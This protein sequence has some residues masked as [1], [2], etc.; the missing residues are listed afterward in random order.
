MTCFFPPRLLSPPKPLEGHFWLGSSLGA[1]G[2]PTA[3]AEPGGGMVCV[4][5]VPFMEVGA[6]AG[7]SSRSRNDGAAWPRLGVIPFEESAEMVVVGRRDG[8]HL[9]GSVEGHEEDMIGGKGRVH[10]GSAGRRWAKGFRRHC[11][12]FE[13]RRWSRDCCIDG[14][15][16]L[17]ILFAVLCFPVGCYTAEP[18]P[19]FNFPQISSRAS[20]NSN[21]RT[22]FFCLSTHAC[23]T[24]R[25]KMYYR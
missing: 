21:C 20:R 13:R 17:D 19:V 5:V 22:H 7:G 16:I 12:C 1:E 4:A 25:V 24:R 6:R 11:G 18:L 3:G 14:A 10:V 15:I 2:E 9:R 23:R 8:V